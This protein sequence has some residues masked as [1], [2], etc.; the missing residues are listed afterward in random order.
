LFWV[1]A[2]ESSTEFSGTEEAPSPI[3]I[4]S[5]LRRRAELDPGCWKEL[6]WVCDFLYSEPD[7]ASSIIDLDSSVKD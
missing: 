7:L 1:V 3:G 6:N 5:F 4:L 2:G